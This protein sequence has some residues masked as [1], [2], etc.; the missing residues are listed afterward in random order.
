[1]KGF[2]FFKML[3]CSR[4]KDTEESND[5]SDLFFLICYYNMCIYIIILVQFA[6]VFLN[7]VDFKFQHASRK[8][9]QW[10]PLSMSSCPFGLSKSTWHLREWQTKSHN[11][12]WATTCTNL[13]LI[14]KYIYIW[15]T[16]LYTCYCQNHHQCL[17]NPTPIW[18]ARKNWPILCRFRWN[19]SWPMQRR[20]HCT[21]SRRQ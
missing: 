14:K 21:S 20:G 13:S 17:T 12:C 5:S 18:E 6:W 15:Y 4:S 1:M 8:S 2:R 10:A 3:K 11:H 7:Y 16:Q 19:V 9:M